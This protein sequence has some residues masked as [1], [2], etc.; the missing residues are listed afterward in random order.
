MSTAAARDEGTADRGPRTAG[1]GGGGLP[2]AS[3]GESLQFVVT[4]LLPSVLRGLFA[5][6]RRWMKW[7]TAANTDGRAIE[8]LSK[9]RRKHGGDGVR[10]LGG[11][12]VT[13]WGVDAIREV[14]DRSAEVYASD[15][16]AKGKGMS[17]FQ[18]DAL[19]LSRGEEWRDRRAFNE[20]VLATSE[21]VHPDAERF[22]YV[23]QDEVGR[24]RIGPAMEW[25]DF[26]RLFDHITLRIIFGD[27]SRGDKELTDLLEKL[28]AE[29][30]RIVGLKPNDDYYELYARLERK[31]QDPEAGSLLARFADAPHSDRTRI[32]HQIPHWMFAMR[33]TLGANA[34][35]ALAAIVSDP[36]VERKAREEI[37]GKDL[38]D[39]ATYEGLEYLEGCFQEAMRLWPTTPLIAR[40]TMKETELAGQKLDEGTQVMI[41]NAFNHRDRER[42]P[43]AD[44]FNPQ[45]WEGG[46]RDYRYNHL[47]NGSQDCPGGPMVLLIGKAVLARVLAEYELGLEE[48]ELKQPLPEMVD[49]FDIRF[50]AQVVGAP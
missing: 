12:I 32:T 16:G 27:R 24:L 23:V 47:S 26:E 49:F 36:S 9:I 34:Y 28:M 50:K 8:V 30:N 31:L 1:G 29:A 38:S 46:A 5:P 37:E 42:V 4:G 3:L 33:D 2:S 41:L 22:L 25:V 39:P 11:R 45:R 13:L 14:L 21:R 7:L 20:S 40:E 6:R 44:R 43:D 19:T 18:P 10:L 48:P 15:S 35:R 17:H